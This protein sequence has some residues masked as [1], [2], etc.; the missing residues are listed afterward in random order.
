MN[1]AGALLASLRAVMLSA[2]LVA[3]AP[4]PLFAAPPAAREALY[5]E[6]PVVIGE[7]LYVAE[8][9]ADRIIRLRWAPEGGLRAETYFRREG[10][11]PTAMAE[12]AGGRRAVLCHLEGAVLIVD[13]SGA[14][15][16]VIT[17]SEDGVRLDSPNDISADG[18]GGAY[19]SN[20]GIFSPH[21]PARGRVMR[22][23]ADLSVTSAAEGLAYAN[24]V[25]VDHARGRVLVSEHLARRVLAYPL[26]ADGALGAPE[27]LIPRA[28]ID[29]VAPGAEPLMGPDGIEVTGEG[30]ILVAL[31]G[32]GRFLRRSP[33]GALSAE[34]AATPYLCNLTIWDGALVLVGAYDN[35]QRPY[36]GLIEI[37]SRAPR[38]LGH[39][40]FGFD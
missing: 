26:R 6:G 7:A 19:F 28:E 25:A 39:R 21:A 18:A 38:R 29:R 13:E 4:A 30:E 12:I 1:A 36:P 10:C 34:P 24:G 17:V 16:R 40:R 35:R 31:Y 23:A 22:L 20:A 37:R 32:A 9:T 3:C 33:G 11:G 5:P 2:A 15:E 14:V 8:M 27:T